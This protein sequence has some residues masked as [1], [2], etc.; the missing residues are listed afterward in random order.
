MSYQAR[1]RV[2]I[3]REDHAEG[4]EGAPLALLEYGD[5]Q[6]PYCRKAFGVVRRLRQAL[7]GDL[8]FVFRHFPISALH[9]RAM[10]ASRAA[11]AAA[12]QGKFWEMHALLFENQDA[13]EPEDLS[14]FAASLGLDLRRFAADMAA[15]DVERKILADFQ[16]GVR[17]GV[18]GTP[19]FFVNDARYDGDWS[20]EA[21]LE[22][23]AQIA[24]VHP[25]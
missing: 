2:P 4:P 15:P 16:G 1:L 18:N 9:P 3:T 10:D 5:F 25:R 14:R 21:F 13:L 20:Y 24:G 11:E 7:G 19:T 22:S 17:T 12:R 8:R 6:C 23:L